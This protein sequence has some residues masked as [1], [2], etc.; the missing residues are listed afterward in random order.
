[1]DQCCAGV[2]A[3]RSEGGGAGFVHRE[4]N[5]AFFLG[6]IDIGVGGGIYHNVGAARSHRRGY[7]GTAGDVEIRLAGAEQLETRR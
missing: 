7:G 5:L 6:A 2:G 3:L 1:V 4:S